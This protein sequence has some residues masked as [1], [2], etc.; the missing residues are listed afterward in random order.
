MV[1]NT[2]LSMEL[3]GVEMKVFEAIN[4]AGLNCKIESK[5]CK[6]YEQTVLTLLHWTL[7][8]PDSTDLQKIQN[9]CEIL[10]ADDWELEKPE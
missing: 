7:L 3:A 6:M 1:A 9:Q 2:S 5:S 4:S 8:N 10:K